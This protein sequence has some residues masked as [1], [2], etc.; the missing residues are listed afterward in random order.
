MTK[1]FRS[2]VFLPSL[3]FIGIISAIGFERGSW[4]PII[5][6]LIVIEHLYYW[7]NRLKDEKINDFRVFFTDQY[8]KY[9]YLI[10]TLI[11]GLILPFVWKYL[12]IW[13]FF[14]FAINYVVFRSISEV[15]VKKVSEAAPRPSQVVKL[16]NSLWKDNKR[17][18]L[19]LISNN[20]EI[21]DPRKYEE[22]IESVEYSSYL[23]TN[24]A[25]IFIK[26]CVES[27]PEDLKN[28]LDEIID[29]L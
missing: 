24:E 29:L 27:K 20:K 18:L 19:E 21:I 9:I 1:T 28:N 7:N 15:A 2:L 6:I 22:I 10:I 12:G 11:I 5:T 3:F 13:T 17:N 16:D 4:T 26:K 14:A 25:Y 8:T 23:R